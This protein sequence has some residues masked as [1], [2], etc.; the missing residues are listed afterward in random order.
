MRF[1]PTRLA[2]ALLLCAL[3]ATTAT[4]ALAQGF[5]NKPIRMV[6]T[7]PAG[8]APDILSRLFADKAQLGQP[9][10]V[11]NVP[12]AGGNIGADRV[13]KAA[14][15]G[16]T[17]VMGTV[18]THSINGALYSKM[19]Y[20]MVK[21]FTPVAHVASAPNLLVVTNSLP[22]K[23]VSELIA[24]MKANP[25]KLSFGSPG[26]GTSVHVSG[27]L[28]KSLTGTTMQHLPYKGRQFAIPD[29][30]GGQIQVMFD[31]MPSAL[32]MAKEGK[33]RAL[34]QTTARR[35]PAAP[36]V[37]TVAETVPGFEATTWFAM[38]APAGTPRDIVMKVNAEMVRVFNLPDVQDKL[39][40]LGLE[41]WISSPED[42]AKYQAAE[43]AKWA[44]VVKDSGAKAD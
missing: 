36:D 44:K 16:H 33:I 13:A 28:F 3:T 30:V 21:D 38:F 35:S 14:P 1:N 41:T 12:G 9:V 32:P 20:D 8:G 7:F 43:I 37:P 42:L 15:D 10:V 4:S 2:S 19:P 22:V 39:K 31:N 17:L 18:G 27:E 34:A 40:T 23:N 6:V 26:I 25:N 29:L 24:Y 5:P 11:D